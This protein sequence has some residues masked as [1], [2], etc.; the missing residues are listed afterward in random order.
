MVIPIPTG[1][2][3]TATLK[4]QAWIPVKCEHC[5]FTFA[6]LTQKEASGQGRSVLWLDESGAKDRARQEAVSRIEEALA[7]TVDPVPCPQCNRLQSPMVAALRGSRRGTGWLCGVLLAIVWLVWALVVWSE[8]PGGFWPAALAGYVWARGLDPLA[9]TG[10]RKKA[11]PVTTPLSR[12]DYEEIAK[13]GW[14][15]DQQG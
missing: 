6:Y 1:S 13:V 15:L 14:V 5:G 2:R 3:H 8:S 4:V 12:E 9:V 7:A 11:A 10:R